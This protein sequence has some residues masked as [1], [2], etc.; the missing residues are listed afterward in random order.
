MQLPMDFTNFVISIVNL[1]E[2]LPNSYTYFLP[3]RSLKIIFPLYEGIKIILARCDLATI[4][5]VDM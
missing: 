2:A 1:I 5:H 4:L 3:M